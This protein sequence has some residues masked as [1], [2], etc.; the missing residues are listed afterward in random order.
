MPTP[1]IDAIIQIANSIYNTDFREKGRSLINLGIEGM[2]KEE[3]LHYF[4]TGEKSLTK[5]G[6]LNET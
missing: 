4:E 6:A 5:R 2:T 1:N 3:I